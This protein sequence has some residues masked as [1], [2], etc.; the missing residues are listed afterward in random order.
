MDSTKMVNITRAKALW[1]SQTS[2]LGELNPDLI[3]YGLPLNC[4]KTRN[5]RAVYSHS[6]QFLR[7][8]AHNLALL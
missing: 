5:L 6:R 7:I 8:L 3:V 2:L 1:G 4:R